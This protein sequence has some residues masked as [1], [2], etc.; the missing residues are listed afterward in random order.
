MVFLSDRFIMLFRTNRPILKCNSRWHW[1][2]INVKGRG[3]FC[4]SLLSSRLTSA[5]SVLKW[6]EASKVLV[7]I[8]LEYHQFGRSC[9]HVWNNIDSSVV[10][11]LVSLNC[12]LYLLRGQTRCLFPKV[13]SLNKSWPGNF[14]S[15]IIAIFPDHRT[16]FIYDLVD[17]YVSYEIFTDK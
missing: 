16:L 11:F 10:A 15:S 2:Y 1:M 8:I 6:R 13:S 4:R 9:A 14:E 5:F 7:P 17:F 12:S 3:R